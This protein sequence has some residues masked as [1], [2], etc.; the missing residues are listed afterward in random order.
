MVVC[1]AEKGIVMLDKCDYESEMFQ[2]LSDNETYSTLSY[3][4]TNKF[5]RELEDIV[6][7]GFCVSFF[8]QEREYL[9]GAICPP[10]S[11][12]LLPS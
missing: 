7:Q 9:L 10:D 1:P 12:S 5:K 11:H 2:I 6:K 3:D 8:R 4:P